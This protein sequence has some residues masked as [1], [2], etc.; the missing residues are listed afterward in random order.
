M[1]NQEIA[2]AIGMDDGGQ[3]VPLFNVGEPHTLR[4]GATTAGPLLAPTVRGPIWAAVV[5][6]MLRWPVRA[7]TLYS[8]GSLSTGR[9]M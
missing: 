6:V 2:A 5:L 4:Y 8:A 3:P 1:D 7:T 9:S